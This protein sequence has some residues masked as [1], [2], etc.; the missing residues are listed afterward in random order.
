[1]KM[2]LWQ[3]SKVFKISVNTPFLHRTH[4]YGAE[5]ICKNRNNKKTKIDFLIA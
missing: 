1:M 2:E 3:K 5:K 4:K